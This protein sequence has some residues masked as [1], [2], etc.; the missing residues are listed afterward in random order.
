MSCIPAAK[1]SS[2]GAS[3]VVIRERREETVDGGMGGRVVDAEDSP[4]L[5]GGEGWS[6]ASKDRWEGSRREESIF[7]GAAFCRC[8]FDFGAS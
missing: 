3:P 4:S 6:D 5:V 1:A 2:V 8:R 7:S